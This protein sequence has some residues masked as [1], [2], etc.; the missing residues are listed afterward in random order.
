MKKFLEYIEEIKKHKDGWHKIQLGLMHDRSLEEAVSVPQI[1]LVPKPPTHKTSDELKDDSKRNQNL[2]DELINH[3]SSVPG[4]GKYSGSR[5][6]NSLNYYT[7]TGYGSIN[8]QLW[9]PHSSSWH[10]NKEH[11]EN[12]DRAMRATTTPRDFLVHTGTQITL[13]DHEQHPDF[14]GRIGLHLPAFTSTS[15]SRQRASSFAKMPKYADQS[16]HH[17]AR[18][19]QQDGSHKYVQ[20]PHAQSQE[21]AD[22][23][24]DFRYG[25]KKTR[26]EAIAKM[27][28]KAKAFGHNATENDH[29]FYRREYGHI[30]D[31]PFHGMAMGTYTHMV[32][33]HVPQ[34]SHGFYAE[35]ISKHPAEQEFIL[36]RESKVLVSAKPRVHH[37][38]STLL[39][40]NSGIV[41]WRGHLVHDGTKATRH[42]TASEEDLDKVFKRD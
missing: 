21:W 26:E 6:N 5:E 15:I 28:E 42:W 37:R 10:D 36:P 31:Q 18:I 27:N 20:V 2:R 16:V 4:Y 29:L 3:Y 41:E 38:L 13:E 22:H 12:I 14:P 1:K 30:D 19:K 35:H 33:L 7:G 32:T 34:G 40:Y 17:Y 39:N 8:G 24:H 9:R 11:I 23:M 25:G